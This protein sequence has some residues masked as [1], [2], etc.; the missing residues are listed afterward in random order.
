MLEVFDDGLFVKVFLVLDEEGRTAVVCALDSETIWQSVEVD[1][2][3]PLPESVD[4]WQTVLEAA[5]LDIFPH[6]VLVAVFRP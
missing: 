2:L 3:Y 1:V 4:T 5:I 6:L